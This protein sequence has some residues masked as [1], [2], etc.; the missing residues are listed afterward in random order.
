MIE[1]GLVPPIR[2]VG[3]VLHSFWPRKEYYDYAIKYYTTTNLTPNE[4]HEL[5]LKEV[6]RIRSEMIK[7]KKNVGF[8]GSLDDFFEQVRNL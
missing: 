6:K 5:G 2:W 8:E 1:F 3:M 7:I 4:I